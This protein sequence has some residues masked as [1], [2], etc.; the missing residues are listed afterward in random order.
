MK[1]STATLL[2]VLAAFAQAQTVDL[3]DASD[4]SSIVEDVSTRVDA[5]LSSRADEIS[6]RVDELTSKAGDLT[7][8]AGEVTS[9]LGSLTDTASGASETVTQTGTE[10]VTE[11]GTATGESGT[12]TGTETDTEEVDTSALVQS[13]SAIQDRLDSLSSVAAGATGAVSESIAAEIAKAT[14]ELGAVNSE[15]SEATETSNP[16]AMPTAAVAMGALM[17]GA[18]I[19]VNM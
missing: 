12:E 5:E 16:G 3:P 17:G 14:S 10:T 15:I 18:A 13:S 8:E 2:A 1:Y 4:L 19:F 6:S 7:S 11:S 9:R